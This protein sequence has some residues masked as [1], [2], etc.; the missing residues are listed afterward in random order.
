MR[1]PSRLM[2]DVLLCTLALV[3]S[4]G[5]GGGGGANELPMLSALQAVY[6]SVALASNGGIH[7]VM[8]SMPTTGMPT[9]CPTPPT[10]NCSFIVDASSAG[11]ASSP[12]TNGKQT[13]HYAWIS[14]SSNL[15]VPTLPVNVDTP[16]AVGDVPASGPT[17][18]LPEMVVKGGQALV[19]ADPAIVQVSY[20][21]DL[22]Q[23]DFLAADGVTVASSET[24]AS[25]NVVDVSGTAVASLTGE[26]AGWLNKHR[27]TSNAGLLKAGATFGSG[28]AW[29]KS[30]RTRTGDTLFT[31]DC[32]L[33]QTST[34]A[35]GLVACKTATTLNAI[36]TITNYYDGAAG[37]AKT[38]TL[39]TD[40]TICAIATQAAGTACPPFG[41]RYWVSSAKRAANANVPAATDSYRV[42]YEVN[43]NVYTGT[44]QRDGTSIGTN[45]GSDAVPS[46]QPFVIRVNKVFVDSLRASLAF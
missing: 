5:C 7:D 17:S 14:L 19:V 37:A 30:T 22:I 11:L 42:F 18:R 15:A 20:V 43:G 10:R 2:Q 45:V 41:V 44:L 3:S 1:S 12:L 25:M 39:A 21:G 26:I 28:A 8:W 36:T 24:I 9:S 40:G 6:E 31:G 13:E 4:V 23:V 16:A 27:L 38:Y 33:A 34:T 32:A 35:A 29:I 46:V